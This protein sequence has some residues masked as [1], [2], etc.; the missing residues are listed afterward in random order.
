MVSFSSVYSLA[1]KI[2]RPGSETLE[3]I[4]T[5]IEL[6][7]HP[8]GIGHVCSKHGQEAKTPRLVRAY[9]KLNSW[10]ERRD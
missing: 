5:V 2:V 9:A 7:N 10:L 6:Q 4:K 8:S 3:V 1:G